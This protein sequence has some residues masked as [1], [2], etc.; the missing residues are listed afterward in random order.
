M[1]EKVIVKK[2]IRS[3]ILIVKVWKR[4]GLYRQVVVSDRGHITG[5]IVINQ[6]VYK[7]ILYIL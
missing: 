3:I 5:F 7:Y 6:I 4:F 2:V 1:I